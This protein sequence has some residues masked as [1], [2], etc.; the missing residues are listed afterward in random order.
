MSGA[1][2]YLVCSQDINL[3]AKK[4]NLNYPNGKTEKRQT[5]QE[6]NIPMLPVFSN[7]WG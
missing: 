4:T 2:Q 5:K 6:G 3:L 7:F 1:Y